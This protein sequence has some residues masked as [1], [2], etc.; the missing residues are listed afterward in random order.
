MQTIACVG[1]DLEKL[2]TLYVG[3]GDVKCGAILGKKPGGYT[4][5]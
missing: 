2:E 3:G 1:E 5:S 4:K